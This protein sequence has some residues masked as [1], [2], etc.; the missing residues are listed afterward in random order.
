MEAYKPYVNYIL[1]GGV[2]ESAYILTKQGQLCGT[3]LPIKEMPRYE[4]QLE[5]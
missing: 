3:N 2:A 5:D 1:S 4:F